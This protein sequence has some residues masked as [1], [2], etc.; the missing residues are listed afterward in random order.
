MKIAWALAVLGLLLALAAKAEPG[1]SN[2]AQPDALTRAALRSPVFADQPGGIIIQ[3]QNQ[4][5]VLA[6]RPAGLL[7][8]NCS[9]NMSCSFSGSTFT[10]TS[11]A[12]AGT[13]WSSLTAPTANL[14][15]SHGAFTTTFTYGAA[16]GAG[17][18]LFTITDTLNN[19]GTGILHRLTTASGSAL[20][21]F[22]ADANGIGWKIGATGNWLPVSTASLAIPGTTHGVVVS[23][24]G[25]TPINTTPTGNAGQVFIS[26]GPGADPSFG[27]PV[28][29]PNTPAESTA[30]WT[31]LTTVNSAVTVTISGTS[32]FNTVV[33]ALNQGSTITG[34]VVTFEV[35]DT[36][37][38]T[39]AYAWPCWQVSGATV[40][41]TYALVAS[42]NQAFVCNIGSFV[43]FRVRLSTVIAGTATVNVGVQPSAAVTQP[44]AV[45]QQGAAA[46]LAGAWPVKV[47]DGTNVTAVKAASTAV[48]AV[49]PSAVVA[50][51]PNSPLP[52]G[53][54]TIGTVTDNQGT[55]LAHT[56]A[57]WPVD[58]LGMADT[59]FASGTVTAPAAG[60]AIATLTAP[61]AGTYRVFISLSSGA[62]VANTQFQKG[63]VAQFSALG[64]GS[65]SPEVLGPFR[66]TL[67]GLTALSLNAT[68]A[69]GAAVVYTAQVYATRIF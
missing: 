50:L 41:T 14:S 25:T 61:P 65:A 54:N 52:A 47:T 43:A 20:T 15:M 4:G 21:P 23:Q 37:A 18:N 68:A 30:A 8:F 59:L 49:D 63:A 56:V 6:T 27:D 10:L 60:A 9:T 5:S 40:T 7:V 2:V 1:A 33:V 22:Q 16:T 32:G 42:T 51:S 13:A 66:I 31:S 67:D 28:V 39:N 55:G 19:T 26:N 58:N 24:S 57:G 69:G 11:S 64:A 53:T 29:S 48:A 38:F 36:I 3:L 34:G 17:V 35:S 12:T 46:A 45:A 44:Y 62:D